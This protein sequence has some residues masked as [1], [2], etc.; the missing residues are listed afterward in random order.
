M[1]HNDQDELA[2]VG[3]LLFGER[4]QSDLARALGTSAR[5]MRYWV[6]GTH[7]CPPDIR[8]RMVAL[9]QRRVE[10]AKE[11]IVRLGQSTGD[12]N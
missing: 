11:M 1:E 12:E 9:L 2:Q 7:S 4:W 3:R 10:D 8:P 6:A 5:M